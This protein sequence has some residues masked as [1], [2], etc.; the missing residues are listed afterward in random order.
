[1]HASCTSEVEGWF[2]VYCKLEKC[3]LPMMARRKQEC[4]PDSTWQASQ[5]EMS[6]MPFPVEVSGLLRQKID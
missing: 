4:K 1:M 3:G 2:I 5:K 6:A